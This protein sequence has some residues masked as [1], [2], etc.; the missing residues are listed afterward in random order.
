M[1][2]VKAQ[3]RITVYTPSRAMEWLGALC[4]AAFSAVLFM[5]GDT[6]DTGVQWTRFSEIGTEVEWAV[7]IGLVAYVRIAALLINGHWRRTPAL[8]AAT[9][10]LGAGL[11]AYVALLFFVPGEPVSTG[12]GVYAVLAGGDL[13]SAWRA[14]KDAAIADW[15]WGKAFVEHPPAPMPWEPRQ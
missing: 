15:I 13:V 10:V 11:W 14:A 2:V 7:G 4:A 9:A 1:K 5:P 8:R 6:F 3:Q 12:V